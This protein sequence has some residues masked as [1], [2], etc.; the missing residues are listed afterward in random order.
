[1]PELLI[2]VKAGLYLLMAV[3]VVAA[4][5]AVLLPNIFHAALALIVTLLGV[6]GIFI[7]LQAEFL[8]VVQILIYV[9]A[10]VTLI[11]FSI[12]LTQSIGDKSISQKSDLG[13]PAFATCV[14]LLA[15]LLELVR[16][17]PWPMRQATIEAHINVADLG[18]S[19][20][21]TYV[22]PFE[23]ISVLL[24]AAL[25]GAVVVAKKEKE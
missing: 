15:A 20:M 3:S 4:L 25:V 11:V 16:L 13:L 10:V 23:V 12:M 14:V 7:A 22:F 1:M 17:T 8:A 18:R 24:I 9:G 21:G 2:I 6:A 5:G 19:L